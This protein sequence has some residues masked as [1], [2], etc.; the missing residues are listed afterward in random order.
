MRADGEKFG[1]TAGGAV[2]LSAERT[3]PYAFYQYWINVDDRDAERFLLQLT[4]LPVATVHEI[5]A[6]HAEAPHQRDAQRRLAHEL[7]ALV[8]GEDAARAAAT[9]SRLLFGGGPSEA[10]ASS[11]AMLERELPTGSLAA[12][13]LAAGIGPVDLLL[14]TGLVTSRND[15]IRAVTAGELRVNGRRLQEGSEVTPADLLHD[16]YLLVRRG[17]KRY[18]LLVAV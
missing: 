5:M 18:E 3:S 12:R 1:K 14:A 13:D 2:W 15:A 4:L 10:P 17:K 6:G 16:R 8:H 11:F 9:A 7:T